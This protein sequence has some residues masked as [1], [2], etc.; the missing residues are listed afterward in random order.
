VSE[1]ESRL[2]FYSG[3]RHEKVLHLLV[4]LLALFHVAA[5]LPPQ[6]E[7]LK[8]CFSAQTVVPEKTSKPM[9]TYKMFLCDVYIKIPS[10]T[11]SNFSKKGNAKPCPG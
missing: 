5:I 6:W 10:E 3:I 8:I 9:S 11:D 1:G 4:L 7:I 2:W